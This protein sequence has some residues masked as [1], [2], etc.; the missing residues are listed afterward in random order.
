MNETADFTIVHFCNN[1]NTAARR[2]YQSH[3]KGTLT[4]SRG[5]EMD[6]ILFF[7]YFLKNVLWLLVFF[8]IKQK[9]KQSRLPQLLL[10]LLTQNT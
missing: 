3:S 1:E 2:S 5:S 7:F 8:Y 9:K 6:S 4:S 10:I